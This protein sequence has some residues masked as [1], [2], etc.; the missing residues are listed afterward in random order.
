MHKHISVKRG[1]L[2]Q[3]VGVKPASLY[4]NNWSDQ[5]NSGV[6]YDKKVSRNSVKPMR[7]RKNILEDLITPITFM[8]VCLSERYVTIS[9]RTYLVFLIIV[10]FVWHV[11]EQVRNFFSHSIQQIQSSHI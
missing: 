8:K 1:S 5:L 11:K 2:A 4:V 7:S 9:K 3:S 6:L 10:R